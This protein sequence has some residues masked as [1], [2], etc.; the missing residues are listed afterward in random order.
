MTPLYAAV[1]AGAIE[2]VR[3]LLGK[4]AA[5][6]VTKGGREACLRAAKARADEIGDELREMINDAP[7]PESG[8]DAGDAAGDKSRVN[9]DPATWLGDGRFEYGTEP[10]G[11]A[12]DDDNES[13][14]DSS[15]APPML[16][17]GVSSGAGARQ[18]LAL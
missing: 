9:A 13:N 2:C 12:G 18:S 7:E 6:S 15:S 1:E 8:G 14:D 3:V 10:P 5:P 16:P 11:S 17:S 4:N